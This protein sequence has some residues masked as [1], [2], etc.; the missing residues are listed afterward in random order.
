MK[1]DARFDVKHAAV[2]DLENVSFEDLVK[3]V[4]L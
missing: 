4:F 1:I 2:V 3:L